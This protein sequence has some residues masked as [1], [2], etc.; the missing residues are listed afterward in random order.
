MMSL[1]RALLPAALLLGVPTWGQEV[2]VNTTTFL[3]YWRQGT[4]GFDTESYA[5]AIQFLEL[6]AT[7][8]GRPEISFHFYGWGRADLGRISREGAKRSGDLAF[9]YFSYRADQGNLEA[10][11][12]RI[13]VNQGVAMEQVDGASFR[14]DLIGGFTFSA[15]GGIPVH[16][17]VFDALAKH[18]YE[19]QRDLIA[20]GRLSKRFQRKAEVGL[21]FIQDGTYP[22]EKLDG[23]N[24]YDFTRRQVAV[25]VRFTPN[26]ILNLSG[27][28]VFDIAHRMEA[29]DGASPNNARVAEHDYN[30]AVR[31][32][33]MIGATATFTERNFRAFYSG[34]TLPSLFNPYEP[35]AFRS[36]SLAVFLGSYAT[37]FHGVVDVKRTSRDGYGNA[38]RF[39]G[40][41]IGAYSPASI[42]YGLGLHRVNADSAVYSGVVPTFYGLS[43]QEVRAWVMHEKDRLT[44][45]LDA[46]L[47]RFD[48]RAN[49]SLYGKGSLY[50]IV[51]SVG[52]QATPDIRISGDL[53]RGV[54]TLM[55]AETMVVLRADCHFSMEQKGGRK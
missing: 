14:A 41:L 27:R 24:T 28:T 45:T 40:E 17:R 6:D 39:G 43:H 25:D 21:S 47:H 31:L 22:A 8:L 2:S 11:V 37:P 7:G 26:T 9:G 23:Y 10:Q 33:P 15:F 42:R 13:A 38:L 19:Y 16:Y 3:Q 30:L 1:T 44:A 49:P 5:P 4:P 35:G 48:D 55:Q 32:T 12:G 20:G 52:F 46:I 18:E 34:S 53:I 36:R 51:G 50:Q 29:P 54:A